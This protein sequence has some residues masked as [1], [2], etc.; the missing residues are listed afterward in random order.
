METTMEKN[1]VWVKFPYRVRIVTHWHHDVAIQAW[2]RDVISPGHPG[3]H[4][5]WACHIQPGDDGVD[6]MCYG[7]VDA[8]DAA[9]LV[10]LE[11]SA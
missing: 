8:K 9:L 7:F 4:R 3:P 6:T 2:C 11:P 10:G 5:R 1:P